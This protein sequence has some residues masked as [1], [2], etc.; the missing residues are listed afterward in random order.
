MGNSSTGMKKRP[1]PKGWLTIRVNNVTLVP[2]RAPRPLPRRDTRWGPQGTL[3]Q[4]VFVLAVAISRSD[5]ISKFGLGVVAGAPSTMRKKSQI[6][7]RQRKKVDFL[8]SPVVAIPELRRRP[9][10]G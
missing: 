10:L 6:V 9:G 2:C 4:P 3:Q 5:D 1:P 8:N 7:S